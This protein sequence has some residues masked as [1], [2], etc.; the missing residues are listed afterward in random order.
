MYVVISV[1]KF[2]RRLCN[3]KRIKVM[4]KNG[5]VVG[6]LLSR[7]CLD[8]LDYTNCGTGLRDTR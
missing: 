3:E 5:I 1:A 2:S 7:K 8:C 6:K 4:V